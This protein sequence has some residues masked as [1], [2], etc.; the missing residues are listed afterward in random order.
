MSGE[1]CASRQTRIGVELGSGFMEERNGTE[2]KGS[3][4]Q[5]VPFGHMPITRVGTP[6][7]PVGP[8]CCFSEHADEDSAV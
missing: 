8:A 4:V 6:V 5:F 1:A 7:Q 2:P 3:K